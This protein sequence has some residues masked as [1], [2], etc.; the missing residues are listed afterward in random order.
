MR[1]L[2]FVLPM[3]LA[4]TIASANDLPARRTSVRAQVASPRIHVHAGD[5]TQHPV[6]GLIT[7]I[8]SGGMW[9]GGID[10]AIQRAAGNQYHAQAGA[11]LASLK[12]GSAFVARQVA[13]H[14]GTFR[15]VVFV[16]DDLK[17]PVRDIVLAGLEQAHA[18]GMASVS[19]PAMRMGVM[20]G[21]VEKTPQETAAGI[22]AGVD[23][24]IAKHGHATSLKDIHFVLYNDQAS[25]HELEGASKK[26]SLPRAE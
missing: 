26:L 14:R 16:T 8:N 23:Q 17:G 4:S 18:A 24:F 25:A 1:H 2:F 3:L 13:K 22:M 11:R 9:F 12:H 10:G 19:L 21:V 5:I 6:D 7:A 20:R 15:D